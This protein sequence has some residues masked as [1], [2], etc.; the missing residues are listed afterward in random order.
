MAAQRFGTLLEKGT[1]SIVAGIIAAIL[2]VTAV[3]WT[4]NRGPGEAR[5]AAGNSAATNDSVDITDSQL[6]A[7]KIAPVGKKLFTVEK[8]AIGSI[9]FNEDM[10]VQVFPPYQ[11]K[12]IST[13]TQLGSD[14]RKGQLLY[15]IDSPD[16]IAAEST[17]ITASATFDQNSRAL[18]RAQKLYDTLGTGGIAEKDLDA[19]VQSKQ[20]AEGGLKA[21]RDAVR[22]FGK[23]DDEIDNIIALRR[24][25]PVLVVNSPITGR[26]TAR[27]AQPGLLAQPG[28]VPAPY[29][30]SDLSTK[31]MLAYVTELDSPIYRVGQEVTVSVLAYPGRIFKGQI[32]TMGTNVDPNTHRV[33]IRSVI[34]DPRNELRPGMLAN[35][36]IQ[37]GGPVLSLS[38]PLNGVVREGDGT[39]TVWV[40]TDRRHF[41]KRVVT[42]GL[43]QDGY[44]QI[45]SGLG[46]GE[47]VVT[48]GAVFMSNIGSAPSG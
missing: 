22:V 10:S 7:F 3:Y 11:G 47:L 28:T 40:T 21:A 36:V 23:T 5:A 4:A 29:S 44:D 46:A 43:Q 9:D 12:I 1:S 37:T 6:P 2:V 18:I 31:W 41:L 45:L 33:P 17:L 19:A 24:I 8:P 32:T 38:M 20:S 30:V 16:L 27:N 25:D 39:M 35:F 15:S 14:V 34:Q 13:T 42:V 26:I 48:D